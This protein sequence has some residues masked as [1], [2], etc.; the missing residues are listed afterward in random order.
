MLGF[1]LPNESSNRPLKDFAVTV[2]AVEQLTG[3]DFF[4]EL[5][6][7]KQAQLESSLT[8]NAWLWD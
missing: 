1:V 3:L 7:E 8:V 6:P 2:D 5:P 4:S